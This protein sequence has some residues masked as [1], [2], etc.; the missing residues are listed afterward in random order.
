MADSEAAEFAWLTDHV[1]TSARVATAPFRVIAMH[2]PQWGWLEGGNAPWIALANEAGVDLVIAGHTHRFSYETPNAAHGYHLLVVGQ[3]QL[4]RVEAT[5]RELK[6]TV[7]GTDGS[8]VKTL[9][10]PAKR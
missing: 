10:I 7:T 5:A 9:V 4:A 8:S 3:D 2:Q 6:V 1:R